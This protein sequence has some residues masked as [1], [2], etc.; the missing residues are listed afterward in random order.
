MKIIYLEKNPHQNLTVLSSM[1][2]SLDFQ[3]TELQEVDVVYMMNT[4]LYFV[5]GA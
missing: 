1:L 3:P 2:S 5:T 4:L